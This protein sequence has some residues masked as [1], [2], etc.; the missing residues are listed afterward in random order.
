M[1]INCSET[2]QW[3]V[4]R[5]SIQDLMVHYN[6]PAFSKGDANAFISGV[7]RALNLIRKGGEL[8]HVTA[9]RSVLRDWNTG[10]LPIYTECQTSTS[11]GQ[12]QPAPSEGD[13]NFLAQLKTRKEMRKEVGLVK[14][15]GGEVEKRLVVLDTGFVNEEGEEREDSQDG[16]G[17]DGND[18]E[19]DADEGGEDGEEEEEDPRSVSRKRKASQPDFPPLPK[20]VAFAAG[21]ADRNEKK[22]ARKLLQQTKEKKQKTTDKLSSKQSHET[23]KVGKMV[24]DKSDSKP[25]AKN[26]PIIAR[27]SNKGSAKI[28]QV[29][30]DAYDF[31][32]FFK[33]T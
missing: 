19:G 13:E 10:K 30:P 15:E 12:E 8:D 11:E 25:N 27:P 6:L 4:S 5:A 7:A 2:V 16:E 20:K 17:D 28:S 1:H 21:I 24:N 18:N 14:L 32:Q 31:D 29:D 23:E 9:A 22:A 26:K 3:I 33:M